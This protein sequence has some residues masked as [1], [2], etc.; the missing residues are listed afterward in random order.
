MDEPEFPWDWLRPDVP[1]VYVSFG[2]L[3]SPEIGTLVELT[4]MLGEDEAQ[5]VLALKDAASHPS[6][7]ALPPNVLVR[8]YAPQLALLARAR[9]M[10]SHGGLSSV[11]ECVRSDVPALVIPLVYDQPLNAELLRRAGAGDRLEL[12]AATAAASGERL[13]ALM[14]E[15]APARERV[16]AL[17]RACRRAD[18]GETTA[19]LLLRLA[20]TRAPVGLP[21]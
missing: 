5:V 10:V 9:A 16:R 8:A 18:G 4:T 14:A 15:D 13:R 19:S 2:T 6:L 12:G 1:L 17:G 21:A 11:V 3:S 7:A 20:E